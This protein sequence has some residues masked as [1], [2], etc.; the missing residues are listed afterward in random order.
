M[1]QRNVFDANASGDGRTTQLVELFA[2]AVETI[3]VG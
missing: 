3:L 1:S 2:E